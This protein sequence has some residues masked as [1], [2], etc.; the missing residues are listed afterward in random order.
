L[1]WLGA[2]RAGQG[3][4]RICYIRERALHVEALP[5]RCRAVGGSA[6]ERVAEAHPLSELDESLT[7]RGGCEAPV[8]SELLSGRPEQRGI[9]LG[10]R[11]RERQQGLRFLGQLGEPLGERELE[12]TAQ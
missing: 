12:L 7:F 2:R 3:R 6:N 9:A 8:E 11:R 5:S 4:D 10:L 1:N